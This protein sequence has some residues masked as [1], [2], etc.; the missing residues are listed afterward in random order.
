M[1]LTK[2]AGI[3][4]TTSPERLKDGELVTA[5]DID[6]DNTGRPLSRRGFAKVNPTALHSLYANHRIAMAVGGKTLYAIE[7][8]FSLTPI[9]TLT[10]TNKLS[11]ETSNDLVFFSNGVDTGRLVSRTAGQWGVT[12]PMG[13]PRATEVAGQ[14]PPGRYMYALTFVRADGHES[15]TGVAGQIDITRGGIVFTGIEV[16]TNPE[17]IYH[18]LYLS[19][20]NGEV[21]YFAAKIPNAQTMYTYVSDGIDLTIPLTTQFAGPPPAG[22]MVRAY[23]GVMYVVVGDTVYYSDAYNFELFR[24]DTN[25]LRFPGRVVM[26]EAVNDGIYVGTPD[27]GG[28]DVE[29]VGYIWFLAGSRPDQLKSSQLFDY[30]VIENSAVKT[31]ASYFE[32]EQSGEQA[33]EQARPIVVWTTRHGVCVGRDSGSVQNMTEVRYS[34]P[35]AQRASAMVRQ[36]RGY[37]VYVSTLQGPGVLTNEYAENITA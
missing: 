12:P 9:T 2:F 28:D 36:D 29:S 8:D 7:S 33:G 13:Q 14:L 11:A 17:V 5:L 22:T 24:L 26:F 18:N 30:G 31:D 3:R 1:E 20:A 34:F 10:S 15:G 6:L 27:A 35:V 21:M 16:S 4:N 37:A 25:F 19:T 32:A 23:N